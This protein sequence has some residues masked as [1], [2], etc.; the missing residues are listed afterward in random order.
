MAPL[1]AMG[2]SR[3]PSGAPVRKLTIRPL[4]APPRPPEGFEEEAWTVLSDAIDIIHENAR[5][6][7]IKSEAGDASKT[8]T[9]LKTTTS[10][11]NPSMPSFEQL[12][13]S[14]EDVCVHGKAS[15]LF[16]R[17]RG[18]LEER[19][20]SAVARLKLECAQHANGRDAVVLLSAFDR[21]WSE[22]C[23]AVET[24][25]R[26]FGY[27]NGARARSRCPGPKSL[28]ELGVVMFRDAF[29]GKKS[30][31]GLARGNDGTE[32]GD[33]RGGRSALKRPRR[34]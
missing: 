33:C 31:R 18:K 2:S 12:Y 10:N 17:A 15:F 32:P 19:A 22:H 6:M 27:L 29:V 16:E 21:C 20:D 13:R 7:S 26:V 24:T 3:R 9:T 34:G 23:A 28:R 8:T 1:G 14:V 30:S 4:K 25:N 11:A 5:A